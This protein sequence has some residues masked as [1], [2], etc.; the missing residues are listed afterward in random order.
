MKY[1]YCYNTELIFFNNDGVIIL[2]G[3]VNKST[4]SFDNFANSNVFMDTAK[5]LLSLSN[6]SRSCRSKFPLYDDIP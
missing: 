1:S 3:Y 5:K 4:F 6:R 2:K